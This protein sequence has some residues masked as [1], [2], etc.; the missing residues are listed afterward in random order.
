MTVFHATKNR[1]QSARGGARS[2]T[3]LSAE[4]GTASHCAFD[5]D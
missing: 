4:V 1:S 3:I 2:T 5:A